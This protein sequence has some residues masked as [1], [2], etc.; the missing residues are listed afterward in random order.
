MSVTAKTSLT[1]SNNL[2]VAKPRERQYRVP[3]ALLAFIAVG[4]SFAILK[5]APPPFFW[6]G[7]T[8]TGIFWMAIW[9]VQGAWLRA[10][11]LN[12][13][14]MALFLAGCEGY[15]ITHEYTPTIFSNGFIVPDD[16]LGWAPAKGVQA[17]AFKAN[18]AGLFHGPAGTLFNVAYTIDSNGLRIAPPYDKDR[19]A[20]TAIFFGC[21]FTFGEGLKDTET[22]PYQVGIQSEGRYRTFNFGFEAYGPNQMLAALENGMVRR[23]VDTAPRYAFYIA[24]PVHVWRVAGRVAWGG[25]APRYVVN[26]TGTVHQSG[27]FEDRKPLAARLGL[28]RGLAQLNKSAIWRTLSNHDSRVTE[29]DVRLYFAV[30]RRSQNLLMAQYPGIQFRVILWP[31]QNG[32]QQR[33]V[34]EK[35]QDGFRQIGIPFDRVEDILPGYARNRSPYILGSADHHPNALADRLI[36]Q[37]ILREIHVDALK[38]EVS[39]SSLA[40]KAQR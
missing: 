31:N 20:A 36:A 33:W 35:M 22:V 32:P 37:H 6:I 2:L 24:L 4:T 19:L 3:L 18:P 8:W 38:G 21:S 5:F 39:Q 9:S 17:H 7:L 13:G 25:H 10:I 30:V 12:L 11:L 14:I 27:Y 29:D 16:I 15:L 26:N 28:K 40:D 34:Y 23:T 1:E